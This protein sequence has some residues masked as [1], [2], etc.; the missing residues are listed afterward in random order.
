MLLETVE[1]IL[2]GK[3][4]KP[5]SRFFLANKK[6]KKNCSLHVLFALPFSAISWQSTRF[7]SA[8]YK[9]KD[10]SSAVNTQEKEQH[11]S[12]CGAHEST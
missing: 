7:M 1:I 11:K 9:H 2:I 3:V 5:I 8:P 4:A 12:Q 6:K 10:S